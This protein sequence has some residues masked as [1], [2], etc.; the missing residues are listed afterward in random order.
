M[1][2]RLPRYEGHLSRELDRSM[3]RYA[4]L[5]SARKLRKEPIVGEIVKHCADDWGL[6]RCGAGTGLM[7]CFL[8]I[9]PQRSAKTRRCDVTPHRGNSDG[10]ANRRALVKPSADLPACPE[11]PRHADVL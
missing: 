7:L 3:A 6:S 1:F 8:I 2:D 11:D 10:S 5:Q 9:Q 4:R